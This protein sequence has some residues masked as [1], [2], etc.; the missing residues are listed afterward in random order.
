MSIPLKKGRSQEVARKIRLLQAEQAN[1]TKDVRRLLQKALIASIE[2][3][4]GAEG[5]QDRMLTLLDSAIERGMA[6]DAIAIGN[7]MTGRIAALLDRTPSLD[8]VAGLLYEASDM[9]AEAGN[10]KD[11]KDVLK[12]AESINSAA[13]VAQW[14][15]VSRPRVEVRRPL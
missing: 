4:N 12:T 15:D 10:A 7:N 11:S 6:P 13:N 2:N 9:L 5:A 1:T 8:H 3:D 14:R